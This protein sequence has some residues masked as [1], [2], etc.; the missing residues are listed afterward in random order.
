MKVSELMTGKTAVAGFTGVMTPNDYVLAID[1]SGNPATPVGDYVVLQLGVEGLDAK[2][3]SDSND[4]QYLRD[5]KST[6]KTGAQRTFALSGDRYIGDAAQDYIFTLANML[7]TGAAAIV[8]YVYFNIKT[9]VGEKGT[10]TILVNSDGGGKAEDTSEID[11]ELKKTGAA[12]IAY[13]YAAALGALTVQSVAGTAS[14]TSLITVTGQGSGQLVYKQN[15]SVLTPTYG[16]EATGYILF[17]SGVDL[18]LTTGQ[19]I[20]VA[21]ITAQG[22]IIAFG[23]ATIASKP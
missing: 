16:D 2:M 8:P 20:N 13:T 4:K 14:G 17:E 15:A 22:K 1:I 23:S 3:E 7:A 9:F 11:V 18:T 21:E 12:P 5:G 19:K 6:T 10:L